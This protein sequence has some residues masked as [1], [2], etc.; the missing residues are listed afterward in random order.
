MLAIGS[1]GADRITTSL[2][3]VLG[4]VCLQGATFEEAIHAPRLHVSHDADGAAVVQH[5]P[6]AAAQAAIAGLGLAAREHDVLDMFFGGVGVA[7]RHADGTMEA[8]GDP[9]REAAVGVVAG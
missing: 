4:R 3:Q 9:R 1:P 5:E 6:D 8:D 7:L 2:M